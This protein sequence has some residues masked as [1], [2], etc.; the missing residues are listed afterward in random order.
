MITHTLPEEIKT[1]YNHATDEEWQAWI[2]GQTVKAVTVEIWASDVYEGPCQDWR[3]EYHHELLGWVWPQEGFGLL[4]GGL[5]MADVLDE[6]YGPRDGY[7][8]FDGH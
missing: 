2:E 3:L 8:I 1:I 6:H 7:H 5:D 4:E